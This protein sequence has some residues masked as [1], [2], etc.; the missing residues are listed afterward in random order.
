MSTPSLT[1]T[2]SL[3]YVS[4]RS[5]AVIVGAIVAM[6]LALAV[7]AIISSATA[8]SSLPKV[9]TITPASSL[10][11]QRLDGLTYSTPFAGHR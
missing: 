3:A 10:A 9:G 8:P 5:A 7:L 11:A 1:S 2:Q 4:R 6:A